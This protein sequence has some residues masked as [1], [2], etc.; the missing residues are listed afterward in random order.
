MSLLQEDDLFIL[1][2]DHGISDKGAH[3]SGTDENELESVFW[4]YSKKGF[5]G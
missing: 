1:V 4:T 2:S 3:G 5:L